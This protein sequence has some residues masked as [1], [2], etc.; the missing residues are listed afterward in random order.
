AGALIAEGLKRARVPWVECIAQMGEFSDFLLRAGFARVGEVA[1]PPPAAW[2]GN[3]LRENKLP[4]EALHAPDLPP[5]VQ[6]RLAQLARSRIQTGHG[7][8]RARARGLD[9]G[10]LHR[11][12]ARLH[13]RPGYFLW[14]RD[15]Q[16]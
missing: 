15:A 6:R 16:R 7:S 9:A 4:P 2:L 13:A 14:S 1:P 10:Q 11:A 12:I 5:P 3:W 8:R